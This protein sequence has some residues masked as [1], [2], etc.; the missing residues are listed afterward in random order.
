V[1]R[2]VQV[3]VA[4]EL[5]AQQM[6]QG[7]VTHV[8]CIEGLPKDAQLVAAAYDLPRGAFVLTF[9]HASF[10]PGEESQTIPEFEMRCQAIPQGDIS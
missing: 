4:P 1:R 3:M 8:E 6:V 5:V 7:K 10:E 9:E 2:L